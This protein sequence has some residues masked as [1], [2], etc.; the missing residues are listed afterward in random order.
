MSNDSVSLLG[1]TYCD[2]SPS[3]AIVAIAFNASGEAPALAV[4]L[5]PASVD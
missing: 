3:T 4:T 2:F 1:S 5:M